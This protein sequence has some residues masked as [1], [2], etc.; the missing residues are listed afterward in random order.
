M[1]WLLYHTQSEG[2]ASQAEELF[3]RH[4]DEQATEYYRLAAQAE[5]K[6]LDNIDLSKKRTLGIT[7]VS[8]ASLYFKAR[9]FSQA[10]KIAHTWLATDSLPFFAVEEMEDLLQVIRYEE[11]RIKSD[12]QFI[13]NSEVKFGRDGTKFYGNVPLDLLKKDLAYFIDER[14]EYLAMAYLSRSQDLVIERVKSPGEVD[15]LITILR[16]KLPTG[17][18]FGIKLQ[19]QEKAFKTIPQE[20]AVTLP[21]RE[22]NYLVDFPFP[23]CVMLFTIEDEKGYCKWLK[24]PREFG[25]TQTSLENNPWC[26]LDQ[27]QMS[28]ILEEVNSFYDAK[29]HSAA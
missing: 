26:F 7:A 19:G 22:K 11:S 21:R 2:Y 17:R 18:L 16:N 15:F 20:I 23:V 12:L 1:S 24:S 5:V 4:E 6:A 14:A 29:N 28:R 8:A 13:K 9:D 25:N 3:R 10:K 27:H